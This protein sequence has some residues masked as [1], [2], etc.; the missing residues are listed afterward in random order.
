MGKR[1]ANHAG[2]TKNKGP[3]NHA[4]N[5]LQMKLQRAQLEDNENLFSRILTKLRSM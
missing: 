3:R 2:A 4:R 5:I 1:T